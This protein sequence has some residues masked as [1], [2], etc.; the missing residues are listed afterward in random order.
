MERGKMDEADFKNA[1]AVVKTGAKR[2]VPF[3]GGSRLRGAA[4]DH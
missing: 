3:G 4:S 1:V 2:E